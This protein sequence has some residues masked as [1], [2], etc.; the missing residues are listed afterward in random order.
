MFW[1]ALAN[2]LS[3]PVPAQPRVPDVRAL[4]SAD[5]WPAFLHDSRTVYTRTTVR[6]D[7]SIQG[8]VV[9]A[10]SGEPKLDTY[11]C[12]LILK[13]AKFLPAKWSDGTEVYGVIRVPV[14][15]TTTN[16]IPTDANRLRTVV[17]DMDFA[18]NKLPDGAPSL[19]GL[20]LEVA[21]DEQGRVVTC[22]ARTPFTKSHLREYPNLTA[23]ACQK[24]STE[25]TMV[26]P[27][28]DAGKPV[29]SIQNVTVHFS[30]SR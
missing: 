14:S 12:E 23:L 1:I 25:L 29:R 6:P 28:D 26:P 5:D 13:R 16:S 7:G 3:L 2:V 22:E 18:V 19:V 15:W 30:K 17:P 24:A 9:E 20:E 11:T 4:F 21:A 27:I 10:K 8:C